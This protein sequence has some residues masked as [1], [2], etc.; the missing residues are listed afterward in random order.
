MAYG[1][2]ANILSFE[3]INELVKIMD[4][5]TDQHIQQLLFDSITSTADCFGIFDADDRL[6]Y[7]NESLAGVFGQRR[8]ELLYQSFSAIIEFSYLYSIGLVIE[9]D[10]ITDWLAY[11]NQKRRKQAFR[12][13]EV[14]LQDG[15]WFYATEQLMPDDNIFF[16]ATDITAK[17]KTEKQLK[18]ASQELFKLATTDALTN[19]HNRRYLLELATMEIDRSVKTQISCALLMIDLDNFK[20]L[21]DKYGHQGGDIVLQ[22]SAKIIKEILRPCDILGRIGGEEFAVLLPETSQK[23]ALAIGERI[24][25]TIENTTI[26]FLTHEIHLTASI[27]IASNDTVDDSLERL[28]SQADKNLYVAKNNGRNLVHI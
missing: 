10:N 2:S 28:M 27:G 26:K 23:S 25:S 19:I 5:I 15:R 7:C 12:N 3:L 8:E 16:Y 22:H 13:F 9:T 4:E 11:A 21:N 1:Y 14:D 24:R 17:K 20:A 6:I 18:L